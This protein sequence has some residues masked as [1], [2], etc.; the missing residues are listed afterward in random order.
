MEAFARVGQSTTYGA[1]VNQITAI[2]YVPQSDALSEML[3][4]VSRRTVKS[5]KGMLSAVVVHAGLPDELPGDGF[6][7]LQEEL[8]RDISGTREER[9]RREF[10]ETVAAYS[11]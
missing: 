3:C 6:Y 2:P 10:A 7:A 8:G 5:G 9:W 4:D 1:L 11:A